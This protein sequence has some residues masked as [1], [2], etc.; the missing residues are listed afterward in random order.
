MKIPNKLVIIGDGAFA[1]IAYEYF[2]H[3]SVYD[4]LAF[5]VEKEYIKKRVI[6]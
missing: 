1:E 3:D 4:V 2:T 5:S 6:I